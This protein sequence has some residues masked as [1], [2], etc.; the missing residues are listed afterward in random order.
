MV[1]IEGG[2]DTTAAHER[3]QRL[4]TSLQTARTKGPTAETLVRHRALIPNPN[5]VYDSDF[6]ATGVFKIEPGRVYRTVRLAMIDDLAVTGIVRNKETANANAVEVNGVRV[7]WSAS[8][9]QLPGDQYYSVVAPIDAVL[10]APRSVADGGWVTIN[11]LEHVY[12]KTP[13]E[14]IIDL[15]GDE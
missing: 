7:F 6:H 12:I 15:L 14:Q 1:M 4:R 11:D 5:T 10:V 8:R 9:K 13:D 3:L 2:K